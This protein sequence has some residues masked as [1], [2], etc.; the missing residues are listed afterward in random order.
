MIELVKDLLDI[1]RIESG[2]IIIDPVP[3]DVNQLVQGVI[4]EV[5]I[6][7]KSKKQKIIISFNSNLPLVNL[8]PSLIRNVYLNL[9]TNAIKYTPE[10]GEITIIISRKGQDILSQVSDN[11]FG[12]PKE[13]QGQAFDKFFRASNAVLKE[14]EGTGLGL[15]LVKAV[16]ES[17]GGKVWFKS[18]EG[19][20]T[21]F[22]FNL[23]IKGVPPKKGEIRLGS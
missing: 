20:G 21:T 13:Q 7:A 14:T 9:L 4:K 22:W 3:T 18:Q 12:I 16:V 10:K 1:S 17:S 2:R 6:K 15:Y 19:Q 5:E 23:P 8:D 11:G